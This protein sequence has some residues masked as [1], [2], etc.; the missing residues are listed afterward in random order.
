[1]QEPVTGPALFLSGEGDLGLLLLDPK[2]GGSHR[3]PRGLVPPF[4]AVGP[5]SVLGRGIHEL[6][7]QPLLVFFDLVLCRPVSLDWASVLYEDPGCRRSG[8]QEEFV[9]FVVPGSG[10]EDSVGPDPDLGLGLSLTPSAP[11]LKM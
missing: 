1:M 8:P 11:G 3:Y 4:V 9:W 10:A 6:V 5:S 7:C 2:L